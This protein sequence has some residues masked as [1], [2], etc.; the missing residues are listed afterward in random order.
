MFSSV[1]ESVSTHTMTMKYDD[2]ITQASKNLNR[3]VNDVINLFV[4]DSLSKK[5][6]LKHEQNCGNIDYIRFK[7]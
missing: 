6:Y 1:H 5:Y 7:V 4:N 2:I 3:T